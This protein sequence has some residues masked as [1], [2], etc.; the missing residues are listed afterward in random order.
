[1][2]AIDS[3]PI[4]WSSNKRS[5]S[6]S[7]RFGS[8]QPCINGGSFRLQVKKKNKTDRKWSCTIK[9]DQIPYFIPEISPESLWV[10]GRFQ[11]E[12]DHHERKQE[13]AAQWEKCNLEHFSTVGA[14]TA[15]K[16][17]CMYIQSTVYVSKLLIKVAR[18]GDKWT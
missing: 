9:N 3:G 8:Q 16:N 18:N 6:R 4:I 11:D 14:E 12:E 7:F 15:D 10:D 2:L 17:I 1:M 13:E 5:A